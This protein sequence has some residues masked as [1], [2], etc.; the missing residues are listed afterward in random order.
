MAELTV[1]AVTV[2]VAEVWPW[3]TVTEPGTLAAEPLE[4]ESDTETPPLPAADVSVTVP[5]AVP[6]LAM[7]LEF[8]ERLLSAGGGGL[9]VT[10]KVL[11]TLEYE[12]VKVTDVAELTVPAVTVKVA[13]V[14]PCGTVIEA[15]TLAAD[16][17]ELESATETPPLPAADVSV[18]VP[19][20][21]PALAMVLEFTERLLRAGGG[22]LTVT[23]KVL[24]TLEY[25]AVKVTEVAELTVPAVTVNVAEVWPWA[26]VTEA[27]TLAAELLELE[28]ATAMPP[29]PAAD[30]R[31]T[32]PVAVPLLAILLELT[33][34]LLS[35]GGGGLTVIPDV[36][37]T[38]E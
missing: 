5:V 23:P 7:V 34:R 16:V 24:L 25:E 1:P 35:A 9:T 36:T 18:T 27:G 11:L 20:A 33:D 26:T 12:A 29:L 6:A 17:L 37:L 10:P 4:L 22:G 3:A 30:V 2:K 13:E 14:C 21:V 38:L 28:S 15:G 31:A 8:T 32:V 19:V